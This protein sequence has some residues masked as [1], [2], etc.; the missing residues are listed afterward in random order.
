[1]MI[2]TAVTLVVFAMG[3]HFVPND[4]HGQPSYP[5]PESTLY[6]PAKKPA[7]V[8][9][10]EVSRP[11]DHEVYVGDMIELE[12]T[13]PVTPST[14]PKEIAL[15]DGFEGY[16]LPSEC[17]WVQGVRNELVGSQT[18]VFSYVAKKPGTEE[19]WFAIV[20]PDGSDHSYAYNF[21]VVERDESHVASGPMVRKLKQRK[22]SD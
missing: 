8:V 13:Y 19:V 14:I 20:G 18:I 10:A 5:L 11:G 17:G 9:G 4:A 21:K 2:R 12:Y 3:F 6:R 22:K 16:V 15:M 7:K 1:M